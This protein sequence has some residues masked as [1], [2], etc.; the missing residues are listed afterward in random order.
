MDT[1]IWVPQI[2]KNELFL[3]TLGNLVRS[4]QKYGFPALQP[5]TVVS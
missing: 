5:L 1:K 2:W 3:A 4:H